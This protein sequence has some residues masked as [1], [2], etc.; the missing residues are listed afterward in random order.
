[1][2]QPAFLDN[3][4]AQA[5][6]YAKYRPLY[7]P[8]L[9]EYLSSLTPEHELAWDCGT[10]NGQAAISLANHYDKVIATD[11]SQQ[12]I[13]NAIPHDRVLYKVAVAEQAPLADA[14]IDLLTIATA[15]HWFNFDVFY[16]E[17]RRVLKPKGI[18]A[19]WAY[20]TP[21]T[22]AGINEVVMHYHNVTVDEFRQEPNRIVE[23]EYRDLPFPFRE[24]GAE[25]YYYRKE[26]TLDD[27][28]GYLDTWSATQHYIKKYGSNPTKQ[29]REEL[30]SLWGSA[31]QPVTWKLVLKIG[32]ASALI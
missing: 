27:F 3:F 1:M 25:P 18:I 26:M 4:S 2:S 11:A 12:Q 31:L 15:L 30:E 29:V 17:A 5:G 7:P 23:H 24:I 13:E 9:F 19:A 16:K 20:G 28:I 22:P 32:A 10:G 8:E 14:S 6:L 21:S